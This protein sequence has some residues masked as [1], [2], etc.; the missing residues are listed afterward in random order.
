MPNKNDSH[1]IRSYV[2]KD[3]D[4]AYE[5]AEAVIES[6][7]VVPNAIYNRIDVETINRTG[8]KTTKLILYKRDGTSISNTL[9]KDQFNY[10]LGHERG[11]LQQNY[12]QV[13]ERQLNP[14]SRSRSGRSSGSRSS[15]SGSRSSRSGSRSGPRRSR[16]LLNQTRA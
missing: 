16:R 4:E 5:Q 10:L 13:S 3:D 8:K 15:G 1:V 14:R 6:E 12:T 2:I 7:I 11:I 9:T